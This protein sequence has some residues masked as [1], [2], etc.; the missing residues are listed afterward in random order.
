MRVLEYGTENPHVMT[1]FQCTAEPCWVFEPAVRDVSSDF[2]VLLFAADGHDESGNDF[3]S[4][5]TYARQ[6]ADYLRAHDI[7]AVDLM[8]GVSLGGATVIRF[9]AAEN[10]P[11][12]KAVID[13]GITPYPYP[14][15]I[16]RLIAAK[17]FLSISLAT[18][19]MAVMK[20]AALPDRWTPAGEDPEEHYR[21]IFEFEK[22]HYSYRTIYN[23]FWSANNYVMP[24]PVPVLNTVIEYWYGEGER[25]A[26]RRNMEYVRTVFPKTSV[27]EFRGLAHAELVLMFPKTF[28]AEIIRVWQKGT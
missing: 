23:A 24:E 28:H 13:A 12:K 2:H 4:V 9:L 10:I 20:L 17:D 11:V 22:N 18:K 1:M 15:W 3:D 6:A 7:E 8:Y 27:R 19:N 21:R 26:R 25:K 16:C 14:R 5:E